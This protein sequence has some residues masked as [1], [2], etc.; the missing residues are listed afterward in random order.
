MAQPP[1]VN[2]PEQYV[3]QAHSLSGQGSWKQEGV[4][5]FFI[6]ATFI[7]LLIILL[8]VVSA[9]ALGILDIVL[10]L[11]LGLLLSVLAFSYTISINYFLKM[12]GMKGV[13]VFL[14]VSLIFVIIGGSI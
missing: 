1:I 8:R 7:L 9:D 2:D 11:L 4:R 5:D 3:F 6:R 13:I 12:M 14:L 10:V